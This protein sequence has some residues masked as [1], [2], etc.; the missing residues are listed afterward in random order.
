M[1]KSLRQRF[2]LMSMIAVFVVLFVIT[3]LINV[4]NYINVVNE[5]DTLLEVL[6]SNEGQFP[7]ST[8]DEQQAP[9]SEASPAEEDGDF[10]HMFSE[11]DSSVIETPS[12]K[13]SSSVP[14][15][16]PRDSEKKEPKE[17]S[18][19]KFSQNMSPETRFESRY[20]MTVFNDD[21]DCVFIKLDHIAA[22]DEDTAESYATRI[23]QSSKS[24]GFIKYYRY[25][26]SL[27]SNNETMII[28]LDCNRMLINF[29]SFLKISIVVALA[30]FFSI[31]LLIFLFSGRII[32]PVQESYEKQKRFITDA[33][34][35]LKTPLTIIDADITVLELES[36]E[37]EWI[38]D[39]RI[40]TSRLAQLTNDLVFL[41]KMDE[42]QAA[43]NMIDFPISDIV[44]EYAQSFRALAITEDK[45]FSADIEPMLEYFGD[46]KAIRKLISILLD[47][48]LKY[49]PSGGDVSISLHKLPK[50]LELKVANSTEYLKQ[51]EIEHLFDRFYRTDQSRNSTT[52]GY[53]LG[54][55]IAKA[56]VQ[57]HKGKIAATA[58]TSTSLLITVTLPIISRK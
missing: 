51:E 49:S 31:M 22:V 37:S 15:S 10:D 56:V 8:E 16:S 38:D 12:E 39:V 58:P 33:G 3:G 42:E 19:D 29:R 4:L 36:G 28:F 45:N 30:G 43:L 20:F 32:R 2:M 41:S 54:L 5:A 23:Y 17:P 47:N 24:S 44:S 50:H 25:N 11:S 53:G 35:E 57:S 14:D 13:D 7:G 34:H 1:F 26:V 18:D 27:N 6:V 9:V 46:T 52:G 21:G 40:Q 48:A 55:S